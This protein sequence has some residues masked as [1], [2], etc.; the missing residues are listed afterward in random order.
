MGGYSAD[1]LGRL[2]RIPALKDLGLSL[3]QIGQLLDELPAAQLCGM[4]RLK[5]VEGQARVQEE[6]A[7]LARVA[8]RLRQIEQEGKMPTGAFLSWAQANGYRVA[9]PDREIYLYCGD[10]AKVR[11]DDAS[12]VTEVQVPV[13]KA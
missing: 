6:Q 2:N 5:Q 11:Q 4:L 10:G 8:A 7:R 9:G 3:E 13:E 1:P 12:Y